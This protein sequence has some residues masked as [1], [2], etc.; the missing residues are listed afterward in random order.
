MY[1]FFTSIFHLDNYFEIQPLVPCI[2]SSIFYCRVYLLYNFL[3]TF[4]LM[5]NL[6][7]DI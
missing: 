2:H 1:A 3:A 6:L 7:K 5:I 4:F